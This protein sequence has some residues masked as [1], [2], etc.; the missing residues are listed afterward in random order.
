MTLFFTRKPALSKDDFID[1]SSDL[2]WIASK[3]NSASPQNINI[4]G[5]P[6]IGKTSLLYQAYQEQ[7]S[8]A[9]QAHII[10]VW[11]AP[12][13][14]AQPDS[15]LFWWT[16]LYA[17]HEAAGLEQNELDFDVDTSDLFNALV[18]RIEQIVAMDH[19]QRV[20]FFIDD[21]DLL[22]PPVLGTDDLNWLR[23]LTQRDRLLT[24]VAFVIASADPLQKLTSSAQDVSPFHNIFVQRRLGLMQP[25]KAREL[26]QAASKAMGWP[27]SLASP[28]LAFLIKEAGRHPDLLRIIAEYYLL[29]AQNEVDERLF[30]L[31][32]ADF[33]YDDHV[34]WLFQTLFNRRTT[35]EREALLAVARRQ[36]VDDVVLLNHLTYRLGL[37]EKTDD[38]G[39]RPFCA[40]F[41]D[42]LRRQRG[43]TPSAQPVTHSVVDSGKSLAPTLFYDSSLRQVLFDDHSAP[44]QLTPV[45]NRLMAYL[46]E[47]AGVVCSQKDILDNVWGPGRNKAVVEKTIN[48]LRSKIEPDPARPQYI[49]SRRGQGYI[50]FHAT[51]QQ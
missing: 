50:L 42:W 8:S 27:R 29:N 22:A 15:K 23:A 41:D 35:E 38:D 26:L 3:L 13:E 17:L 18:T 25:D 1:R 44:I 9:A 6:R 30:D 37:L 11:I 48:R 12:S 49:V 10:S 2:F 39:F 31:V 43:K 34:L 4:V 45:E 33:R 28:E 40:A 36:P 21:F 7:I 47:H 32:R 46:V 24:H 14:F 5:E 20:Y 19:G 16:L 51:I